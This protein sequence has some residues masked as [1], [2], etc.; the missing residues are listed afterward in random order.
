[1]EKTE[2]TGQYRKSHKCYNFI[3]LGRAS[4]DRFAPISASLLPFEMKLRVH[5]FELKSERLAIFQYVDFSIFLL[6]FALALQSCSSNAFHVAVHDGNGAE[7]RRGGA[8][9]L[10]VAGGQILRVKRADNFL[11]PTFWQVRG[12]N[13]ALTLV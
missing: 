12:Q 11:T 6:D 8:T 5:R 3:H 10:R 7:L 2:S 1:M 9:V 4:L 13:T